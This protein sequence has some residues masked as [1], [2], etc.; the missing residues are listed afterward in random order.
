MNPLAK[1]NERWQ[2]LSQAQKVVSIVIVALL[3]AALIY[4]LPVVT[5][6]DYV[7]L[8]TGL[9][10]REAGAIVE[11]LKSMKVDYR[12]AGQGTTIEVPENQ[13]Y[14]VRVQLASSGALGGGAGFE[15]FDRNKLGVT[16]FEQRV[17]YQR[18]L[19]EELRR[20][21]VQ[22]DG[23]EQARVHLVIPEKSIFSEKEGVP[24]ASIALRTTPLSKLK[25]EQ[26]RGI[27]DLVLGSVEGLTP[28]NVHIVDVSTGEVLSDLIPPENDSGLEQVAL[29]RQQVKRAYEKE[30]E[31][32]VEQ[33]LGRILGPGRA[34]AMVSVD[35]DFSQQQST[36]TTYGQGS[37]VSEQ[38]VSESGS[39]GAAAGGVPG[40]DANFT[41]MPTYESGAAA[42]GE[43]YFHEE[44]TRNYQLDSKSETVIR[45]PGDVQRISAAVVVD[46][47]LNTEQV[48]QIYDI[49]AT[50]T[51]ADP[52]RGDRIAVS[53]I[54]FNTPEIGAEEL[55]E[56]E[57]LITVQMKRYL[58]LGGAGLA[59]LLLIVGTIMLVRALRAWRKRKEEEA[60]RE[61][62]SIKE[63]EQKEKEEAEDS[64]YVSEHQQSAR[65]VARKKPEEVA[66]IIKVW[67]AED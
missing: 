66:E 43:N 12:L 24:S 27:M 55:P 21:I 3:L 13:V 58:I 28:E 48:Q 51:G 63:M 34:V 36:T 42:G 40:T 31:K 30:L 6:P 41:G 29:N 56:V 15:L 16:D 54:P 53:N 17:D 50:A 37:V 33:M 45:P 60:I 44:V 65:Q 5:K 23:V 67:L 7:P 49:V 61:L 9:D 52:S 10:V 47:N 11:K 8:F 25:P 38:V 2:A 1:L 19:Q 20:T 46:G 59:V 22:F 35:M 26:V 62:M 57:P 14:E 39:G 64:P 18:A 4:F 32:R